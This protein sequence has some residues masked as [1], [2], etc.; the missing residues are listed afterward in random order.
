MNKNIKFRENA[1]KVKAEP[2]ELIRIMSKRKQ[3]QKQDAGIFLTGVI[4]VGVAIVAF[5]EGQFS[6]G[7]FLLIVGVG[8]M[9]YESA[10]FRGE[11]FHLFLKILK[12]ILKRLGLLE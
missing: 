3:P 7:L 8:F 11:I 6:G 4:L 12:G 2:K 9:A 10:E 5:L 1:E